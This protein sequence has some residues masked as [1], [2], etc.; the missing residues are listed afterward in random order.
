MSRQIPGRGGR[1]RGMPPQR[2]PA[3]RPQY[4]EPSA[5]DPQ[6]LLR[7]QLQEDRAA[8]QRM[9]QRPTRPVEE[10]D[11]DVKEALKGQAL[12]SQSLACAS[13]GEKNRACPEGP[14]GI[15]DQYVLLDSYRRTESSNLARGE[16]HFDFAVQGRTGNQQIGTNDTVDTVIEMEVGPFYFPLLPEFSYVTNNPQ[17]NNG[18]PRLVANPAAPP[19]GTLTGS[20]T[21]LPDGGRIVLF[22]KELE[23]QSISIGGQRQYHFEFQASLAP[24][25]DRLLLTPLFRREKFIFTDPINDIHGLTACFYGRD[26]PVEIPTDTLYN[27]T[28]TTSPAPPML[29]LGVN[30]QTHNLNA[31]DRVYVSGLSTADAVINDYVNRREGLVVGAGT[32][33]DFVRFNPDIDATPLGTSPFATGPTNMFI[34]KNRIAIPIR[35]RRVVARTTNYIDP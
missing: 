12:Q 5:M 2:W 4:A 25:N 14:F 9:L 28:P 1:G 23:S 18:L 20:L 24:T 31:N 22:F 11:I 19:V 27:L 17:T 8:E 32:T 35:F 16:L 29:H 21:Q 33:A 6:D 10:P 3:G 15:S 30:G 13:W 34:P 26:Q 7:R